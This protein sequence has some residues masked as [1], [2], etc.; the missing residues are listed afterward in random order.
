MVSNKDYEPYKE[1]GG[2]IVVRYK[3]LKL[4]L[5]ILG[6]LVFV[7]LGGFFLHLAWNTYQSEN[8][9]ILTKIFNIIIL[10]PVGLAS[11]LFFGPIALAAMVVVLKN[12]PNLIVNSKGISLIGFR[13]SPIEI[14]WQ[15]MKGIG[16]ATDQAYTTFYIKLM[17]EDQFMQKRKPFQ[18]WVGNLN[19][20]ICGTPVAI[21][22]TAIKMPPEMLL[23]LLRQS[24]EFYAP[25]NLIED[26]YEEQYDYP[27]DDQETDI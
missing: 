19:N 23:H 13:L 27:D 15:E 17:D 12:S 9:F 10:I 5:L 3:I 25:E 20:S 4:L 21:S 11:I 2:D 7:L 26:E 22:C 16:A 8:V 6:G 14:A 24:L 1:A 18:R